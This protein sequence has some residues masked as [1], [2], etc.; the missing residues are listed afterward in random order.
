MDG[1][2]QF[3]DYRINPSDAYKLFTL[4]KVMEICTGVKEF[5]IAMKSELYLSLVDKSFELLNAL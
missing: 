1:L 2:T 5:S 3:Q 4:D